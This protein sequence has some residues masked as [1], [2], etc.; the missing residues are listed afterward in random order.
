MHAL[1]RLRFKTRA[2]V[3]ATTIVCLLL[4]LQKY[5]YHIEVDAA[6]A[7]ETL[8]ARVYW[9]SD[10]VSFVTKVKLRWFWTVSGISF[11][12]E[13]LTDN[14]FAQL[15]QKL[16]RLRGLRKLDLV[17]TKLTDQSAQYLK[18]LPHLGWLDIRGTPFSNDVI[19]DLLLQADYVYWRN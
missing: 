14:E 2:L 1:P 7:A 11:H 17:R 18:E 4:G 13:P 3:I 6:E 12:D 8:G 15:S 9:H 19:S 16:V 10:I 5:R